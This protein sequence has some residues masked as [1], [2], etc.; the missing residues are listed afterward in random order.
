MLLGAI[1][2]AFA[3]T[4]RHS[5]KP[6]FPAPLAPPNKHPT[7]V[8][9][10]SNV[11]EELFFD[12]ST[13][14]LWLSE[15]E[16][17]APELRGWRQRAATPL[18]HQLMA[19]RSMSLQQ[20]CQA[21]GRQVGFWHLRQGPCRKGVL[22]TPA[23]KNGA[24][25]GGVSHRRSSWQSCCSPCWLGT[26]R[27]APP[28]LSC[29][30]TLTSGGWRLV[31]SSTCQRNSSNRRSEPQEVRRPGPASS[32]SNNCLFIVM[33]ACS[34]F[35]CLLFASG[36]FES[37]N[38]RGSKGV[39]H[40]CSGRV[41]KSPSRGVHGHRPQL[42]TKQRYSGEIDRFHPIATGASTGEL[43]TPAWRPT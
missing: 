25:A 27:S 22:S 36:G 34:G 10:R 21:G 37:S 1:V 8:L 42:H 18:L 29:C 13:G 15:E 4:A 38:P 28:L 19:R 24:A 26:L 41:D 9:A 11:T 7:Q 14:R 39:S 12:S 30:D 17:E 20:V 33:S 6:P 2:E 40:A 16:E 35:S 31:R 23:E 32:S 43:P 5:F 3:H